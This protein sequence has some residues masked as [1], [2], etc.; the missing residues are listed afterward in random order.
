[1]SYNLW[2]Q[3]DSRKRIQAASKDTWLTA[4][5]FD[6][7]WKYSKSKSF[8]QLLK[9]ADLGSFLKKKIMETE[10]EI[11]KMCENRNKQLSKCTQKETVF[12]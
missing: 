8:T 7:M 12:F 5:F 10:S 1:M 11:L 4:L 2:N 3:L 9:N 6:F